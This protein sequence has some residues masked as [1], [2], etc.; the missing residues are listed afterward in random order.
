MGKFS[1]I[2]DRSRDGS[3][4]EERSFLR[5]VLLTSLIFILAVCLKHDNVFRWIGAG[6]TARSQENQMVYYRRN[7]ERLEKEVEALNGDRDTLEK[8]AR[9]KFYFAAPGEDVYIVTPEK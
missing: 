2:W 1:R 7:I 8:F 4:R 9:E 6:A 3:H 5:W